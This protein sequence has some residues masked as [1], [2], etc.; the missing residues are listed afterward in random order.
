MVKWGH[1]LIRGLWDT[2]RRRCYCLL[3]KKTS[4]NSENHGVEEVDIQFLSSFWM[5][6]TSDVSISVKYLKN[7]FT[8][9]V[10]LVSYL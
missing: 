10:S 6:Y 8:D 3:L 7:L 4:N 2:E 9:H 1:Y 5:G